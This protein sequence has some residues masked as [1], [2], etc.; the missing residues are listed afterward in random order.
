MA[1]TTTTNL[2]LTKPE[3]G[4]STDT[5]GAKINT[6]LDTLDAV[7]KGDGTGTSVGLNVGSGKTLSVGGTLT[8]TGT[9]TFNAA[10]FTAPIIDNPK[11]GYATTATAAGTTTLT[12]TSANQQFFTGTTTQTVVLPVTSTL[13]L[14]MSYLIV[15]NSTGIIT[16]QSSGAN[17]I[18]T[19]SAGSSA[20]FT[21][22]LTS[23]TTA[24]SWDYDFVSLGSTTGTGSVVLATSPT[25]NTPTISSPTFTGTQTGSL[26]ISGTSVASTSGT[27]IDFTGIPSW[28]KRVT[29]MFNGV[30]TNGTNPYI[31]QLGYSGGF[32]SATYNSTNSGA[33]SGVSSVTTTLGLYIVGSPA[34]GGSGAAAAFNGA[35]TLTNFSG[36]TWVS[37]AI[38]GQNS[39]AHTNWSGGIGTAG[40]T[41]TQI[42]ITT[43]TGVNTFDAGSI[44][45]TYE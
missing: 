34:G 37:T 4:A 20:K 8:A 12:V 42:R 33:T 41:L 35:M 22:I 1:D 28:V 6:D 9:Q 40:G 2:L 36:N 30:S 3:V 13:A 38:M 11:L 19:I 27:S 5:W 17:T 14:G 45:I 18:T 15:N 7:F 39:V 24:A 10:T 44:N 29:V 21:C 32:G 23:G 25:I 31:V 43:T 26:I 16:V